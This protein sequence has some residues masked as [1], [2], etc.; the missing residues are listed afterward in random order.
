MGVVCRLVQLVENLG[1]LKSEMED[2]HRYGR[3]L[4]GRQGLMTNCGRSGQA[5]GSCEGRFLGDTENGVKTQV[6]KLGWR[7]A[8]LRRVTS[9]RKAH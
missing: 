4:G 1:C 6:L 9:V 8:P 2:M 5:R 3:H 7:A